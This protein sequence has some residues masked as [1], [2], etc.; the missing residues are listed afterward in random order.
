MQAAMHVSP[1]CHG[2]VT[3]LVSRVNRLDSR[4]KEHPP[5][6]YNRAWKRVHPII[7][8]AGIPCA[9]LSLNCGANLDLW[10]VFIPF[11]HGVTTLLRSV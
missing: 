10:L 4:N 6:R 7:F 11:A 1:Q 2:S 3:A 5:L 9:D 8:P